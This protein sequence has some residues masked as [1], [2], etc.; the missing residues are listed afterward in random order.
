[1]RYFLPTWL[2]IYFL[3]YLLKHSL[4]YSP[5]NLD[6]TAPFHWNSHLQPP[7]VPSLPGKEKR[8]LTTPQCGPPWNL[9]IIIQRDIYIHTHTQYTR[10]ATQTRHT[11]TPKH[12]YRQREC[13]QLHSIL[14]CPDIS[15]R[16]GALGPHATPSLFSDHVSPSRGTPA[17]SLAFP[18]RT[19][20]G[21][22]SQ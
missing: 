9:Q 7:P 21:S 16:Q 1:M 14:K 20:P 5:S 8:P 18:R 19:P 13:V 2:L 12:T 15:R 6:G 4:T 3:P 17:N 22:Q 10:H 11:R